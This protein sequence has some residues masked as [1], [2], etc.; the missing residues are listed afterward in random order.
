MSLAGHYWTVAARLRH[1][2]APAACPETRPFEAAV[3]DP[4]LG[5]L[6]LT[7]RLREVPGADELLVVFHGLGGSIDSHYML[8]AT[9]VAEAAGLSSLRLNARGADGGGEDFPHAGL[10]ADLHAALASPQ[11]ARYRRLHLLGYSLGGHVVLRL[12]TEA[13]DAR[14]GA[15]AAVCAPLDLDLSSTAFDAPWRWPYRRYILDSLKRLYAPVAARRIGRLTVEDVLRI[16]YLR[17]WDERIVGPR[18]GFA[19]AA[20][21]YAR[22]SVAP[23]LANLRL[24][25][26]LLAAR[27]DPMVPAATLRLVLASPAPNLEARWIER[28]GHV[29][30]PPSLG[31]EAQVIAWLRSAGPVAPPFPARLH[32]REPS[33]PRHPPLP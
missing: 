11:L 16:R 10:T 20:D 24:P 14:L 17:E 27:H 12:A 22:E 19:G 6:R 5:P 3:I 7:G 15:V 26:L 4:S 21:Y 28:G 8:R 31:I 9:K 18:H 33:A 23:R 32:A 29:A 2:V 30:F 1:A 25:A 13:A